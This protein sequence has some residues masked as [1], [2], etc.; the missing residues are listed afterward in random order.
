MPHFPGVAFR[1]TPQKIQ[2][3]R[4][5]AKR[6][7]SFGVPQ[8][9][10]DECPP[11]AFLQHRDPHVL[12]WLSSAL[13]S[14]GRFLRVRLQ[15]CG[16]RQPREA[17]SDVLSDSRCQSSAA[18]SVCKL[19]L[20]DSGSSRTPRPPS[21]SPGSHAFPR[22]S[23][24][25]STA[26]TLATSRFPWFVCVSLIHSAFD[27]PRPVNRTTSS[28]LDATPDTFWLYQRLL[29]L[30]A[31]APGLTL[32]AVIG[33]PRSTPGRFPPTA[34]TSRLPQRYQACNTVPGVARLRAQVST[35]PLIH[36]GC[37]SA[38]WSSAQVLQQLSQSLVG[39]R[40]TTP[41]F[42]YQGSQRPLQA[43]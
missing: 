21:T 17:N 33:F 14:C 30:S 16:S 39:F 29:V 12:T 25:L 5:V 23:F 24:R 22:V 43:V 37:I 20:G 28:G 15:P 41:A 13:S 42:P 36:S 27:S 32:V 7:G 2:K 6:S 35:P 19:P 4:F 38:P 9:K 8:G 10:W 11:V 18:C 40:E 34:L 26:E 1:S 31:Q 3:S